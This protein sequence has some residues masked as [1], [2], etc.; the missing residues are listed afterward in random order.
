MDGYSEAGEYGNSKIWKQMRSGQ[1][2]WCSSNM[3]P[4]FRAEW[5]VLSGV[6][7]FGKLFTDGRYFCYFSFSYE[8]MLSVLSERMCVRSANLQL[9]VSSFTTRTARNQRQPRMVA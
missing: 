6:A 9:H 2:K 3:K 5:V 7:D 8:R 1:K 4:R